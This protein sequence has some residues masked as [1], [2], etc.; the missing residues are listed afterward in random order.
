MKY[1][2]LFVLLFILWAY[3]KKSLKGD[4]EEDKKL[5]E[6]SECGVYLPKEDAK[7]HI[8]WSKTIYFCSDECEKK[9]VESG[10]K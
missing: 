1:F 2:I 8:N 10:K 9:Y 5:V 3:L 7:K 4:S 6:C